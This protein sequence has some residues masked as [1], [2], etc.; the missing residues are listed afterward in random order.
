MLATELQNYGAVGP[1]DFAGDEW[2][3]LRVGA[4]ILGWSRNAAAEDAGD[5][6]GAVCVHGW[7]EC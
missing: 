1:H 7:L 6:A 2:I 3:R 5:V 4:I